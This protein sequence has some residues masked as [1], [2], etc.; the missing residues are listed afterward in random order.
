LP[1]RRVPSGS[2]RSPED[3]LPSRSDAAARLAFLALPT[4]AFTVGLAG[5]VTSWNGAAA[6]AYGFRDEECRGAAP[7]IFAGTARDRFFTALARALAGQEEREFELACTARDG[8]AFPARFA[9]AP[10]REG[11][12]VR[13]AVF[14][15]VGRGERAG[16]SR[17]DRELQAVI[18]AIPAP[19]WFKD[20]DGVYRGCNV[21]FEEYL[22]LPRDA[23]VGRTVFD[24]AP[25]DLAEIYRKADLALFRAPAT[26]SYDAAVQWADGTRREVVFRK[27]S[28]VDGAGRVEGLAGTM[29]DVTELRAAERELRTRLAQ[30]AAL[31]RLASRALVDEEPRALLQAAVPLAVAA[32]GADGGA[33]LELDVVGGVRVVRL[34]ASVGLPPESGA[35]VPL[36]DDPVASR[37]VAEWHPLVIDDAPRDGTPLPGA[38]RALGVAS[39]VA[40]P[41]GSREAPLGVLEV[42]RRAPRAFS[43]DDVQ[44]LE[45]TAHVL[46]IAL[47]RGRALGAARTAHERLA[48]AERLAAIGTLA[49]GVAHEL[50]N[51]LTYLLSS[52]GFAAGRLRRAAPDA[53]PQ[54][55]LRALDDAAEGAERMRAIV[56]DLQTVGS[57]DAASEGPV[58]VRRVAE[59]VTRLAR[60][61][62]RRRAR[63]TWDVADAPLVRGNEGR[64]GQVLLNLV[65]NAAHAIP[66]GTPAEHE[67]RVSARRDGGG[68]VALAVTDTG[69]GVP[70]EIRDR[71]FDPFF[72]TK[73]AGEGTGLGLWIC[74]KIVAEMGGS[75]ALESAPG[76]G[77]TFRVVLPS[78]EPEDAPPARR[79]GAA[80][81]D[82]AVGRVARAGGD[83]VAPPAA[84]RPP[85][86]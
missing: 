7:R 15:E 26:Q 41:V 42:H 6:S 33:V 50:A 40:V 39:V 10:L 74:H 32:Q 63:L 64:L 57:A 16:G 18:D 8:A 58:D 5:T 27:A 56:R 72:T 84:R 43:A 38:L 31:T 13:G 52:L 22:G 75:I 25:P 62:V 55:A 79:P 20:A 1:Q 35:V 44:A 28:I 67:I 60:A 81:G 73:P 36:E 11:G 82:V 3:S 29:L 12:E 34:L 37:V 66:E 4:P 65:V 51:P 69:F 68:K 9:A 17:W 71:I 30:Q 2:A 61:E 46:A 59:Y 23:I 53:D 24:V 86:A 78:A 70:A 45:A 80:A 21:A 83:P 77:S 19:I 85:A 14:V 76:K 47:G 54:D 49:A 48:R